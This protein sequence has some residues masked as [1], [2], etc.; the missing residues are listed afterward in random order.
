M[1]PEKACKKAIA[2]LTEIKGPKDFQVGYIAIDKSGAFGAYSLKKGF[3]Y[4]IVRNGQ[5][6]LLQAGFLQG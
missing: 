5:V 4:V 1:N 2:R 6:E 3:P